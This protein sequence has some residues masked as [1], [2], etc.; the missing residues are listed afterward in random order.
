M[1]WLEAQPQQRGRVLAGEAGVIL[2][3]DPDTSAGI[4]VTYIIAE[5]MARQFDATTMIKGV[6]TLVVEVLSPN[7]TIEAVN[8]KI[9]EDLKARVPHI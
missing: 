3:R 1:D 5:V 9:D 2:S 6:P 4:D 8:E 7:D